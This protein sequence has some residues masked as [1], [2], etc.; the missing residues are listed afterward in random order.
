MNVLGCVFLLF[1]VFLHLFY[2]AAGVAGR[3]LLLS[4]LQGCHGDDDMVGEPGCGGGAAA[5]LAQVIRWTVF[6][7]APAH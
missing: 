5:G 6:P 3:G 4:L 1:S 7:E 2:S